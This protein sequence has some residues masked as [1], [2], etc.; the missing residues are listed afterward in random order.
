MKGMMKILR[1]SRA[2][3]DFLNVCV[4]VDLSVNVVELHITREHPNYLELRI[5]IIFCQILQC[6]SRK[7]LSFFV[8]L[9]KQ[10]M[11]T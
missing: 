8:K 3:Y 10:S 9:V 2:I 7:R 4:K 6:G 5:T 1:V 11:A